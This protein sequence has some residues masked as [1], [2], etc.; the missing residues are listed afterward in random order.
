[1]THAEALISSPNPT[2]WLQQTPAEDVEAELQ[3]RRA[4]RDAEQKK[5]DGLQRLIDTYTVSF[6][7]RTGRRAYGQMMFA[8]F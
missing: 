1:M 8:F 6:H 7:H 2:Q 5:R 3:E 4:K